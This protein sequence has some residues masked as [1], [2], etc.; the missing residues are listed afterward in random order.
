LTDT[1][2]IYIVDD[3]AMFARGL[4]RLVGAAG[5]RAE[6]FA[7]ATD[8]L[9]IVKDDDAGCVCSTSGCPP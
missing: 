8:F 2:T 7:S 5:L 9:A 4:A 6:V 1:A 3:D